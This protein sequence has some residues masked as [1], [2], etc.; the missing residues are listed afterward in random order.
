M[1]KIS[2]LVGNEGS[3]LGLYYGY[4][5]WFF[6]FNKKLK[7]LGFEVIFFKNITKKFYE[8]DYLFIN[9]R[10]FPSKDGYVDIDKLKEIKKINSNLYWF[11]M[12]DSAGT[13]QFEVLPFVKKYI[14]KSFYK[15]KSLY[16][17]QLEGGRFYT[18]F[19]IK[20]YL[21]KDNP[22]YESKVLDK[23]FISKLTLGWNIGVA[24]F[25]DHLN[26]SLFSYYEELINFKLFKKKKFKMKLGNH[27]SWEN[28]HNK[29]DALC[30]M[31]TRFARN[32]V[33]FQRKLLNEN[34][35][36]LSKLNLLY[37]VRLNKKNYYKN[38][39][40]SKV[41]IGA[42]GWG[43]VC[44]REFEAIRSGV[45]FL[46]PNMS[47]IETWPNIYIENETYVSYNYDFNNFE[48]NLLNL[49]SDVKL[50]KKLV[51]NSQQIL[52]DMHGSIGENYFINKIFEIV[53]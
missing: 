7:E 27:V 2:I 37:D 43:E 17:K 47:N 34:L 24:F 36:K 53:S 15:N 21:I 51:Q 41:S 4:W 49:I 20:K 42:F 40:N 48:D 5:N 18:D 9:S 14:K 16:L 25:F 30:L 46:F 23:K 22:K 28:D 45:A 6:F 35:S 33:G 19:Y 39:R 44:Y 50:R 10:I 32:S 52:D 29:Y 38:L 8:S 26:Y 1:K 12:R 13:T 11:D 31:N 3:K